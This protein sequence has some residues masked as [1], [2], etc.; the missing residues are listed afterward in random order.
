MC[1]LS[2]MYRIISVFYK[3]LILL[4]AFCLKRA[5]SYH[6]KQVIETL[7]FNYLYISSSKMQLSQRNLRSGQ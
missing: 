3:N 4:L 5:V 7:G 6:Y 1:E 2:S